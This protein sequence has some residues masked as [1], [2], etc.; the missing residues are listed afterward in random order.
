VELNKLGWLAAKRLASKR[1]SLCCSVKSV[2][3]WPECGALRLIS[4]LPYPTALL[5]PA[6]SGSVVSGNPEKAARPEV[7]ISEKRTRQASSSPTCCLE[8]Q[9]PALRTARVES[10]K[11]G[12]APA[13]CQSVIGASMD[14]AGASC[15]TRKNTLVAPCPRNR[16]AVLSSD[17]VYNMLGISEARTVLHTLG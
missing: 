17:N 10:E 5:R 15:I 13:P 16:H 1:L 2:T 8:S 7:S 4:S 3:K 9:I 12:S 11:V 14:L 6:T